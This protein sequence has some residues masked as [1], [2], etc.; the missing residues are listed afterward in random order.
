MTSEKTKQCK[1]KGCNNPVLT[2]NYCEQCKQ[3][4]TEKRDKLLVGVGAAAS[5]TAIL[6]AS[7]VKNKD[8]LKQVPKMLG[9]VVKVV[10][11]K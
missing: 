2:G 8:V 3:K 1:S 6:A 9:D 11:K 7:I 4:R 10:L 5:G